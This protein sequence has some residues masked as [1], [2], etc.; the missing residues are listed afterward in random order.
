MSTRS[1]MI[2]NPTTDGPVEVEARYVHYD[3]YPTGR[4]MAIKGSV[5]ALGS[6]EE[7][8]KAVTAHPEW[9]ALD[10]ET[11]EDG[12]LNAEGVVP[13][14]G[15]FYTTD[16]V[17]PT[18]TIYNRKTKVLR[19]VHYGIEW[20]YALDVEHDTVAVFAQDRKR[21]LRH[22]RTVKVADID[23]ALAQEVQDAGRIV[24]HA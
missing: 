8:A 22:V 18:K 12:I 14:V 7:Y 1:Y 13:N 19:G 10:N 11:S 15:E 3:G 6:L 23:L 16:A 21:H 5:D 24:H 20:A 17:E 9:S 2:V 4:L